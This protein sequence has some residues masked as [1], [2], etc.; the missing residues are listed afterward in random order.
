MLVAAAGISM[1]I[2]GAAQAL[3]YKTIPGAGGVPLNVVEAGDKAKPGILLVHGFA[4]SQ[5]SFQAQLTAPELTAA[6]HLVAFDLRGH[7]NSGK[8]WR[9]EDYK[10][11]KIWADDVLAVMD[12]TG[13]K[14]PTVVGWSYG[15]FV[16]ANFIEHYGTERLGGVMLVGSAAGLLEANFAPPA[17]DVAKLMAENRARQ[18][19]GDITQNMVG[20]KGSVGFLTAKP[21]DAAWQALAET[22]NLLLLPYVRT[23]MAGRSLDNRAVLPK[24]N[25]PTVIMRGSVDGVITQKQAEDLTKAIKGAKLSVFDGAGHSPFHEAPERF[26]RELAVFAKSNVK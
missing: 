17:P 16:V 11:S 2:A 3:D 13:L 20:A 6:Y 4:Q 7:G 24:I 15:G 26:N 12:A 21:G 8:P 23:A 19:S 14:K 1:S 9:P 18:V 25:V 22:G 10:D 5:N